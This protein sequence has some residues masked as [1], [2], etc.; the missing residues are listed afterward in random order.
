MA[1]ALAASACVGVLPGPQLRH[2]PP[3]FAYGAAVMTGRET[4]IG[5]RVIESERT[6][7]PLIEPRSYVSIVEYAGRMSL[8]D[9]EAMRAQVRD[10]DRD[11]TLGDV[12]TT[13][14]DWRTA[15]E[16]TETSLHRPSI[17]AVVPYGDATFVVAFSAGDREWQDPAFMRRTVESFVRSGNRTTNVVMVLAFVAAGVLVF[18][19][20]R[21]LR[22]LWA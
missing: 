9:V 1:L 13:R 7:A 11:V 20:R 16:W 21:R 4:G 18:V 8:A 15:W 3:G 19:K 17:V 5:G 6:Y 12:T 14:I 10:H 2:P 22:E